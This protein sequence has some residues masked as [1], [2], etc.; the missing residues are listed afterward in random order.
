MFLFFAS[1]KEPRQA[2]LRFTDDKTVNLRVPVLLFESSNILNLVIFVQLLID[3]TLNVCLA[4]DLNRP[5]TAAHVPWPPTPNL[6]SAN[7]SRIGLG[8]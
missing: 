6:A 5:C 8:H 1:T 7:K 4:T 3:L 2:Q